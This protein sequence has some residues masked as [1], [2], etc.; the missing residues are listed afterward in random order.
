MEQRIDI[1][2]AMY[3]GQNEETRLVRSRHGQLEYLTT[4]HYIETYASKPC[5]V[6]EI[7]AGT[8]RYSAALAEQGCT[9]D[10]VELADSNFALLSEH[11]KGMANLRAYQGDALDLSRFSDNTYDLTLLFGPMYHLYTPADQLTAL[12]EAVRVTKPGGVLLTAFLSVHAIL[13]NNYLQG[14]LRAGLEENF[15]E[16]YRVR[17]FPEQVFTGFNIDEFEALYGSLPVERIA[18]VSTDSILEL[19]EERSDFAMSDEEFADFAA[20][21]LRHCERRELLGASAHLL[22]ICRKNR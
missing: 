13:Y 20:Y 12:R 11:A 10:A 19:A 5:R 1:I 6:L 9:V 16:A 2:N 3:N 17:H 4:M 8:G 7:G 22:H 18:T 21:H 15:S 14:N